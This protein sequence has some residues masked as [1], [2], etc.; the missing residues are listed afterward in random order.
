[1][2]L[3]KL[4]LDCASPSR[5]VVCVCLLLLIV[6]KSRACEPGWGSQLGSCVHCVPGRASP[7]DHCTPCSP[8][9]FAGTSGMSTCAACTTGSFAANSGSTACTACSPGRFRASLG[10]VA[11]TDCAPGT[12]VNTSGRVSCDVCEEGS[13]TT[14]LPRTA[15]VPCP[16]REYPL[17][18][19]TCAPCPSVVTNSDPLETAVCI[20]YGSA[21]RRVCPQGRLYAASSQVGVVISVL[22]AMALFVVALVAGSD[23]CMRARSGG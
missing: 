8:G 3:F 18:N 10:G 4:Q 23:R 6:G 5:V 2:S 12:F 22:Y 9:R 19:Q 7:G 14:T 11:C 15:C 21:D 17:S 13:V 20:R 16:V 1:M